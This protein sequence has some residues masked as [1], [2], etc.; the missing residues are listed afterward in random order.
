MESLDIYGDL[1]YWADSYD[2][3]IKR[4]WIPGRKSGSK[5]GYGQ[6]LEIK[7]NGKLTCVKVDQITGNLYWTETDRSGSKPKGR[8]GVA[9]S[10]GRYRKSLISGGLEFPTS[11]A[12]DAEMGVMVFSDAG[13]GGPKVNS[14][15][16]LEEIVVN[17]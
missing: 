4:S 15:F 3:T 12:I 2:R 8:I 6:D 5:I 14:L 1:I 10:D 11:L 9:S 16:I 17:N 7:A 13:G